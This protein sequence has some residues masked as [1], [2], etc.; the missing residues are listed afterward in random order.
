MKNEKRTLF[1]FPFFMKLKNENESMTHLKYFNM[2]IVVNYLN[3]VFHVEVKTNSNN[4]FLN[5]VFQLLRNSK[6]TLGTPI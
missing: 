4:K 5:L 6:D 2:K 1:R 3:F